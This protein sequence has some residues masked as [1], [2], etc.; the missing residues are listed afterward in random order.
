MSNEHRVIESNI[1]S[2]NKVGSHNVIVVA[3]IPVIAISI[4]LVVASWS[5]LAEIWLMIE[6]LGFTLVTCM[7]VALLAGLIYLCYRLRI[8]AVHEERKSRFFEWEAGAAWINDAGEIIHLSAQ[9]EQAKL[10]AP[11]VAV[12]EVAEQSSEDKEI[13]QRSRVL[14]MHLEEGKGMH[15][16]ADE[17]GYPYQKVRDWCNTAKRLRAKTDQVQA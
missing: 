7:M 9:H 14:T 8:K 2:G 10:P 1:L 6:A 12:E 13:M 15:A 3:V 5:H 16:I 11:R 17:T 4:V